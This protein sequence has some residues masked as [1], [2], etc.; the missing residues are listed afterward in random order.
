MQSNTQ[1]N[2]RQS[3]EMKNL[4]EKIAALTEQNE[5]RVVNAFNPNQISEVVPQQRFVR[6]TPQI[7][8]RNNYARDFNTRT[9]QG[10]ASGFLPR[11]RVNFNPDNPECDRCGR[12]HGAND[13]CIAMGLKCHNC[14]RL[15]HL[16]AKCR[17][18]RRPWL[19]SQRPPQPP[20][21]P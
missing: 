17:S 3:N 10:S 15:N 6:P 13:R 20:Q 4:T 2:E 1:A 18:G 5:Q 9:P 21:Q 12:R 8:Q 11:A 14:Q 16:A 7:Q 19:Q